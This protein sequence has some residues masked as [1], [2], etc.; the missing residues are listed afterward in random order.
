MSVAAAW[1]QKVTWQKGERKLIS[2]NQGRA[3]EMEQQVR[4][5]LCHRVLL[6][7][8]QSPNPCGE[9]APQIRLLTFTCIH[10]GAFLHIHHK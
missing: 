5:G 7:R 1:S 10:L 9:S 6:T 4:K 3:G 2:R 8:I